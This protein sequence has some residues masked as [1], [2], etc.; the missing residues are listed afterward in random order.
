MFAGLSLLNLALVFVGVL[1][2][3][4]I[5]SQPL[6]LEC[7]YWVFAAPIKLAV[8]AHC[9]EVWL[10]RILALNPLIYGL[11]WWTVWRLFKLFWTK[12]ADK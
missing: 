9:P 11:M 7:W 3:L 1:L 12:P 6:W 10:W 8:V 5:G 4:Q 2:E